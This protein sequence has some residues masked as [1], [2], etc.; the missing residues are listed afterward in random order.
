MR[1]VSWA[2]VS[3]PGASI[4]KRRELGP[5][6]IRRKLSALASLFDHL[7]ERNAVTHNPVK[8]V[9]RPKSNSNEG[10]T[11]AISDA[12]ARHLLERPKAETLKGKRDRA[13]LATPALS[14]DQAGRT[15]YVARK[16]FGEPSG[17]AALR[18]IR[19]REQ[20]PVFTGASCGWAVDR[21]IFGSRRTR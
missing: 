16:G 18:N 19:Q 11:P 10:T 20:N 12:E 21:G 5:A 6:T 4:W 2:H 3:S 9:K 8:G 7:C 17:R 14:R 13:I 15:V 1:T